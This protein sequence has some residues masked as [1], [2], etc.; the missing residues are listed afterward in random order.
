MSFTRNSLFIIVFLFVLLHFSFAQDAATRTLNA[1]S[2]TVY[3]VDVSPDCKM[4]VTGS[5]DNSLKIWN[6]EN[7]E[8]IK[9]Y[10]GHSQPVFSVKFSPDGKKLI[11][12]A[13]DNTVKLWDVEKATVDKTLLGHSSW[14]YSACFSPD[15]KWVASGGADLKIIIWDV[16]SG[17]KITTLNGHTKD[18]RKLVFSKNGNLLASAAD[19]NTIKIWDT[20]TWTE[21]NTLKG[22]TNEVWSVD[23][24]PN[25]LY[26]VSGSRDNTIRKWEMSTG[27][28]IFQRTEPTGWVN[29]VQF[30]PDG[31]VIL[32]S[33]HEQFSL[34]NATN[35]EY[36]KEFRENAGAIYEARFSAD[37]KYVISTYK[38]AAMV[39]DVSEIMMSISVASIKWEGTNKS[40]IISNKGIYNFEAYIGADTT[41]QS[42]KILANDSVVYFQQNIRYELNADSSANLLT[43]IPL[44]KGSNKIQVVIANSLGEASTEREVVFPLYSSEKSKDKKLVL[45]IE[46]YNYNSNFTIV[47]KENTVQ[48]LRKK[49][50]EAG[51]HVFHF[52]NRKK[53]D[54]K[55]IAEEMKNYADFDKFVVI[56]LGFS[57]NQN[58][59]NFIIPVD[60]DINKLENTHLYSL[61]NL[62]NTFPKEKQKLILI[63]NLN[64][65]S[66]VPPGYELLEPNTTMVIQ[67]NIRPD[68]FSLFTENLLNTMH[69]KK[70][71]HETLMEVRKLLHSAGG[72]IPLE[73]SNQTEDFFID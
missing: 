60:A 16:E 44:K 14:V 7:G 6:I 29:S 70:S 9:S 35:G 21:R 38:Q 33:S 24:S 45:I 8:L 30:S 57:L 58:F 41:L 39:W 46:N 52:T 66:F 61:K 51:Y 72:N 13:K 3:S 5:W 73:L 68:M 20:K 47:A 36:I 48:N 18:V 32:S 49:L 71:V 1:H 11:S 12:C 2:F 34:W 43:T 65:R 22:H 28:E 59:A 26:L 42:V 53:E 25:N 37:S 4:A 31:N 55:Q 40:V 50:M 54:L 67:N 10:Y 19:D 23:F 62:T 63:E 15:G 64:Y 69:R 17:K 56:Y 27:K